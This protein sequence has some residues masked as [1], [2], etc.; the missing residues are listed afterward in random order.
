MWENIKY[1]GGRFHASFHNSET[2]LWAR[3]QIILGLIITALQVVDISLFISDKR[4]LQGYL[5]ANAFI[6]EYLRRRNSDFGE[7]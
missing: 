2:I 5:F 7:K 4:L 1:Y 6:T 3:I